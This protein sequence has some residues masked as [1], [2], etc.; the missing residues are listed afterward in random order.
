MIIDNRDFLGRGW[1]FPVQTNNGR[2]VLIQDEADIKSSIGI[3][4]GTSTGERVMRPRFGSRLNEL[5][6][7][8]LNKSTHALAINY[9]RQALEEWEPR[10]DVDEV[11]IKPD[12]PQ[13]SRLDIEVHYTIRASNM[14]DNLVYPFYLKP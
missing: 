5:V 2:V 10:I 8:A 12:G 14:P 1:A 3:I 6:F 13:A 7:A 4:L 9:T 11:T